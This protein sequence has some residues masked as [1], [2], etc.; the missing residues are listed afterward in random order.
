MVG[1]KCS[2]PF[3]NLQQCCWRFKSTGTLYPGCGPVQRSR[4]S[5]WLW[6]GRSGD[7]ISVGA[8]FSAPVQIGPGAHRASYIMGTGSFP[9]LKRPGSGVD[10]PPHLAPRLK[11]EQSYTFTPPLGL[12]GLLQGELCLLPQ[13]VKYLLNFR[14]KVMLVSPVHEQL[15]KCFNPS[16][17]C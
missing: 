14:G 9:G 2:A 7:Q 12:R 1:L 11:K 4:Y 17:S 3:N 16:K 13:A 8:R 15:F 5:D 10:H 6:P